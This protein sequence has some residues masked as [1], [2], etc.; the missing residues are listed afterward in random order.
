[1]ITVF[2]CF[3][4]Y[5]L[6]MFYNPYISYGPSYLHNEPIVNLSTVFYF[7][8]PILPCL[9]MYVC[10]YLHCTFSAPCRILAHVLMF[11]VLLHDVK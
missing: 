4:T 10:I 3:T 5:I 1:M 8:Y 6:D 7:I 9:F 2:D 11:L